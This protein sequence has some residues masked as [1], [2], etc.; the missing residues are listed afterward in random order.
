MVLVMSIP[1]ADV[2]WQIFNRWRTGRPIGMA[3]RG[4]LH[5]RLLDLGLSPRQIVVIYYGFCILFGTLALTISNRLYK[6]IALVTLGVLI[7]A[8]LA[9]LTRWGPQKAAGKGTR[10]INS[11]SDSP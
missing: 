4:H 1:I 5:H 7:I 9:F 10:Q 11:G 3:D 8:A 6:L 2:A